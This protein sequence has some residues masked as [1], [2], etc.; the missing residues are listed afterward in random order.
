MVNSH[1]L[2]Q[3][4]YRGIYLKRELPRGFEPRSAVSKT[5]VLT[6]YTIEA[7]KILTARLELATF[8]S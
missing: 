1:A 7:N 2:Y 8:G 6:N 4:S 3:L 5:A